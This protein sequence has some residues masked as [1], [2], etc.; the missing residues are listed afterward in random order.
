MERKRTDVRAP[1]RHFLQDGHPQQLSMLQLRYKNPELIEVLMQRHGMNALR[2][3]N[4]N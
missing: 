2:F 4:V 1:T 3:G